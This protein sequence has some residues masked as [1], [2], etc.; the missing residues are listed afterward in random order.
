MKD[1]PHYER[2]ERAILHITPCTAVIGGAMVIWLPLAFEMVGGGALTTVS[3]ASFALVHCIRV[4]RRRRARH[5][6][7]EIC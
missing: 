5:Q 2:T 3:V 7:Q 6:K 1:H 4:N